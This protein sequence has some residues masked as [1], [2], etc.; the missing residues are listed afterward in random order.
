MWISNLINK[1]LFNKVLDPLKHDIKNLSI[2]QK[3][4]FN[5]FMNTLIVKY[6]GYEND[7]KLIRS[8]F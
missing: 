1:L 2:E 8:Y 5:V 7:F 3:K 6:G 4:Q